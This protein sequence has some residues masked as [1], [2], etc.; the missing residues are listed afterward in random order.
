MR[1]LLLLFALAVSLGA[2]AGQYP[3][4]TKPGKGAAV[5]PPTTLSGIFVCAMRSV[6]DLREPGQ[7]EVQP[8]PVPE[9]GP[10]IVLRLNLRSNGTWV[11]MTSPGNLTVG[12]LLYKEGVARLISLRGDVLYTLAWARD[13]RGVEYLV[14]QP[15]SGARGHVCRKAR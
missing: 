6:G 3:A 15:V 9:A 2:M 5:L 8:L 1:R 4:T 7:F 13:S 11:D 12:K 10:E 14:Q